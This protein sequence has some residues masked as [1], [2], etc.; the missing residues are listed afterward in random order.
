MQKIRTILSKIG[1]FY[2]KHKYLRVFSIIWAI[3]FFLFA[4]QAIPNGL[5]LP[6]S[7]DY[8]LQQLH[9]YV[10]GHD[11]FWN[12]F[13][14]GEFQMWSYEGYLGY[15]Y[16]AGNTFYYL[17]SPFSL[18]I[19]LLPVSLVPQGIFIMMTIK[20]ACG[21]LFVYILLNKF[22]HLSD[23]ASLTGA[24]AYGLCGW[25]LYYVWFNHFYDVLA[26]LPLTLLGVE[27]CVQKR[28]GWPL[29]I[30][31]LVCGLVNYYFLFTFVFTTMM[32]ALFRYFQCFKK[33]KGH[34]LSIILQGLFYSCVGVGMCAFVI[35][36][37]I[38]IVTTVSRVS[39]SSL[40]MDFLKFF[41]VSPEKTADGFNFGALKSF[42]AFFSNDNFKNLL[43]YVFV[44]PGSASD[45]EQKFIYIIL[46]TVFPA[47]SS[48]ENALF[49]NS[50]YDNYVSN[51]YIS[52]PM[53]LLLWPTI[54][55]NFR[56]KKFWKF[57]GTIWMIFMPFI[58][59]YFYLFGGFST[60]LYGRW[61]I[62]VVLIMIIA[63]A[64]TIDKL[65]EMDRTD[66]IK[67]FIIC[68]TL[69]G[70]S[71]GAA[72]HY[73]RLSLDWYHIAGI[74]ILMVFQ[75]VIFTIMYRIMPHDEIG[76]LRKK[77]PT[78]RIVLIMVAIDLI[79]C[80]N[81]A[82][83]G[84]G[85]QNYWELYG[86]QN[87]FREQRKIVNELQKEDPSFYRIFDSMADRNTNNLSLSLG[88]KG[89]GTFHSLYNTELDVFI[90][91]WTRSSYTSGNWSM[92]IDEKRYNL[93]A[94]L[95]VKYYLLE[96]E[97]TNIPLGYSLYKET[98]HYKVYKN[99]HFVELG[100]AFDQ[101]FCY[102]QSNS[103]HSTSFDVSNNMSDHFMYESAL[104]DCAIV[105]ATDK[106]EITS[107]M[108][109]NLNFLDSYYTT[110]NRTYIQNNNLFYQPRERAVEYP[111]GSTSIRTLGSDYIRDIF[112]NQEDVNYNEGQANFRK[113]YGY[114][115]YGPWPENSD[116][117]SD[118]GDKVIV[119]LSASN[120]IGPDAETCGGY[121]VI[122]G[123][124][125]GPNLKI[126]FYHG[127]E[128]VTSDDHGVN[129]YDHNGDH[130][131]ARGFYI[132]KSVDRIE[133]EALNDIEPSLLTKYGLSFFSEP[134]NAYLSR[135]QKLEQSPLENISHTNN[136]IDFTTNYSDKRFVVLSVPYDSGWKLTV[137]GVNT[138]YYKVDGG[139]I[140]LI[141]NEGKNTYH[142]QYTSPGINKGLALSGICAF[143]FIGATVTIEIVFNK[144]KKK[145]EDGTEGD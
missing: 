27:Y 11:A 47:T 129:Y 126:S 36:P 76:I 62:F 40:L 48:W 108:G 120:V 122:C 13:K 52:T 10:E 88:Y 93:D 23:T 50:G 64:P 72:L 107:L 30:A 73:E 66:L 45:R 110:Y 68:L 28:K 25:G 142:L 106:E 20:I 32:Y 54:K 133:I 2:K 128:L 141:A 39:G 90:Q 135:L 63:T 77:V 136:T 38:H 26:V 123:I 19:Y 4:F 117:A 8:C 119:R 61:L 84:Q 116:L 81:I 9:F 144:K 104:T 99:D 83:L 46:E 58:P 1:A 56:S 43:R 75:I 114:K 35:F 31:L 139:F 24:I 21:G 140:G 100:Y 89:L 131:F 132:R 97:D 29:A 18:P 74:C 17:T 5:T 67:S 14:T 80:G 65:K 70:I 127:D 112:E 57:F 49:S 42:K 87:L 121:H 7:G 103:G 143:L 111:I 86:G 138:K 37:A 53:L 96:K 125:Y 145:E 95:N 22:F 69:I 79:V 105:Q 3:T 134:Y 130:K 44:Y 12:F 92:G 98:E 102:T 55:L 6:V 71:V 94:F 109:S 101:A 137:N 82:L 91:N 15:N 60:V 34:N 51:L 16:F 78:K 85:I 118:S 113:E 41:F 124:N 115:L 33:N 59:F